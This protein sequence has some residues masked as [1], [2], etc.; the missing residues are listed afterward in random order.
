MKDCLSY[1]QLQ[2]RVPWSWLASS[3]LER[4]SQHLGEDFRG[5]SPASSPR[6]WEGRLS[7]EPETL[8]FKLSVEY[9]NKGN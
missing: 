2:M 1:L 9:V 8:K 3:D 5:L 6:Q 4:R 7:R